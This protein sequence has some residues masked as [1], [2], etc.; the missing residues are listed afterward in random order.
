MFHR[1]GLQE[2]LLCY[3]PSPQMK[4]RKLFFMFGMGMK[5]DGCFTRSSLKGCC[6]NH[7][8]WKEIPTKN[9]KQE[10]K[11]EKKQVTYLQQKNTYTYTQLTC[12]LSQNFLTS[13]TLLGL[14]LGGWWEGRRWFHQPENAWLKGSGRPI[15]IHFQMVFSEHPTISTTSNGKASGW[16]KAT[17][18]L[19]RCP[20]LLAFHCWPDA[21]QSIFWVGWPPTNPLISSEKNEW[22]YIIIQSWMMHDTRLNPNLDGP[23]ATGCLLKQPTL[24][25]HYES[26]WKLHTFL[27]TYLGARA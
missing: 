9:S 14:E 27:F 13:K 20:I 17:H 11:E 15:C 6:I 12:L 3:W 10:K 18:I 26:A 2:T 25:N 23:L 7:V 22:S 16:E 24:L 19:W 4:H 8:I 1:W 5:T 21:C